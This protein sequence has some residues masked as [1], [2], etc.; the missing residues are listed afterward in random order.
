[1]ENY[2]VSYEMDS[3]YARDEERKISNN[4]AEMAIY[5]FFVLSFM[6]VY[7]YKFLFVGCYCKIKYQ[8]QISLHFRV[9]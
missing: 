7:T 8:S 6:I 3:F 2:C 9:V 1:M 5:R 4:I